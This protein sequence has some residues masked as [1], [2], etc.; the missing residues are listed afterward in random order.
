MPIQFTAP[1]LAFG[2]SLTSLNIYNLI[3]GSANFAIS[4]TTVNAKIGGTTLTGR[5]CSPWG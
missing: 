1:L 2:G 3:T 5:R 4:Q